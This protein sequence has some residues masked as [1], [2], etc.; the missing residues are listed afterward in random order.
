M[1]K[2]HLLLVDGDPV[3]LGALVHCF[4]SEPGITFSTAANPHDAWKML[5]DQPGS[6]DLMI[7]DCLTANRDG[8]DLLFRIGNDRRLAGVPIIL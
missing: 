2:A 3:S 6:F 4:R 5:Q 1:I 7:L 8:L